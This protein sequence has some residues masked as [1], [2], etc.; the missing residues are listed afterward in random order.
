MQ[1]QKTGVASNHAA[2]NQVCKIKYTTHTHLSI[3]SICH[4]MILL[5][6][7]SALSFIIYTCRTILGGIVTDI[8]LAGT[9]KTGLYGTDALEMETTDTIGDTTS[10]G[11]RQRFAGDSPSKNSK[12]KKEKGTFI[13][14]ICLENIVEATKTRQGQDSHFL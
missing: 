6:T 7:S 9:P 12:K 4:E 13:C 1:K 5:T 10:N 14:P 11:K 2:S 8:L 3:R